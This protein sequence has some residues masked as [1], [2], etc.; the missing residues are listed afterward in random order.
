MV[1]LGVTGSMIA[2]EPELD[3]LLH[4][5]VSY[6]TPGG[7]VLSLVEMGSAASRRYAGEPVVAYLPST[8]PKI[9]TQVI[10]PSGIV[11][12]NQ[13]TGAVLGIRT[14]GWTLLGFV[15]ALHVRLAAG[16]VGKNIVKWS[17]VAMVISLASGLYLWWPLKRVRIRG[18]WRSRRFWFDLHNST[19]IFSVLPLLALALTGAVIGFED[20]A[21]SLLD[22]L[23]G[24]VHSHSVRSLASPQPL[25]N[26]PQ[27]TPDQAVSIACARVSEA[28]PYRVQTPKYGG[29]YVVALDTQNGTRSQDNSVGIDPWT[30]N[31]VFADLASDL[32]ARERFMIV[33]QAIHTGSL[34]GTAGKLIVALAGILVAMQ[35]LSG[36]VMFLFRRSRW[37]KLI[38]N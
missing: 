3:R 33:N 8:S 20:Q 2:F 31:I 32:T 38:G 1:L 23:T 37:L 14:R 34:L 25:A 5:D 21:V 24:S 27:I 4:P 36:L 28:I 11:A 9:A 22:K 29:M 12:V 18:P 7:R 35:V 30:G 19:G 17:A 15:R 26:S 6:V 16:A 13:Y 10:L